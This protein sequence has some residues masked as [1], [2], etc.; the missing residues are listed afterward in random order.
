MITFQSA[1]TSSE[2]CSQL[3]RVLHG[4]FWIAL[5]CVGLLVV[6]SAQSA[7]KEEIFSRSRS[8]ASPERYY[9]DALEAETRG[10][11]AAASLELRRSLVL[12]P[13]FPEARQKLNDIL[14]KMGI[15]IHS[16]WKT[17]LIAICPPDYLVWIGSFVGWSG[18]FLAV[19][20][21]FTR[22]RAWKRSDWKKTFFLLTLNLFLCFLGCLLVFLGTM[23]DPRTRAW[24]SVVVIPKDN[25]LMH[26]DQIQESRTTT[27]L[28]STP[29]E[30]AT[31]IAQIPTGTS[32][33]LRS[34]HGVWSYV[35]TE[36]GQ[37]G[38][39]A[40]LALQPLVPR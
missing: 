30:N 5:S 15:P 19:W 35:Q 13:L 27:P 38:W 8:L 20:I 10:D 16:S 9:Q 37:A 21:F 24:Q 32:L 26:A 34:S 1:W 25:L 12:N 7:S 31:I 18:A 29:V 11:L 22:S 3:S 39:M 14:G 33:Y 23:I 36:S 6:S 2:R 28:R 40:S 17:A 4:Y